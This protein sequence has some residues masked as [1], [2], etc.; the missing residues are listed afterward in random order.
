MTF[1]GDSPSLCVFEK[2]K[3]NR[4]FFNHT[5]TSKLEEIHQKTR[6]YAGG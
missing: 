1:Q 6:A 3:E 2:K 5:E 4:F